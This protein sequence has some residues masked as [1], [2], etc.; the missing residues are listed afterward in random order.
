VV[1]GLNTGEPQSRSEYVKE[2]NASLNLESSP[3]IHPVVI[4]SYPLLLISLYNKTV[5]MLREILSKQALVADRT[6]SADRSSSTI[7]YCFR[8]K[9]SYLQE[10]FETCISYFSALFVM[11][12]L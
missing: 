3:G 9:K 2:K 7:I 10:L 1:F 5:M 12:G 8:E 6:Y 4:Y 11:F